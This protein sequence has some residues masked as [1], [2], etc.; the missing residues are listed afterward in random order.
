MFPAG[1]IKE[2]NPPLQAEHLE[3]FPALSVPHV[4]KGIK[5][6]EERMDAFKMLFLPLPTSFLKILGCSQ[7]RNQETGKDLMEFAFLGFHITH[8]PN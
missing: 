1:E 3:E 5:A 8:P 4:G 7:M 2:E 6:L